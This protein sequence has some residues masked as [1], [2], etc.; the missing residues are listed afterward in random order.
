MGADTLSREL[1]T[2]IRSGEQTLAYGVAPGV[3][4]VG[5]GV[6]A[7]VLA[8]D[9]PRT[10]VRRVIVGLGWLAGALLTLYGALSTAEKALMGLGTIDTPASLEGRVDWYLFLWDPLWLLGGIL[11]LLAARG[12]R[13]QSA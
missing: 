6:L 12:P 10:P 4:K 11:F 3:V 5:L 8:N 7:M 9:S 13:S 1:E 2:R